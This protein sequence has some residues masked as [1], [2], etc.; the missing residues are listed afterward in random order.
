[1][2]EKSIAMSPLNRGIM[3]LSFIRCVLF[4]PLRFIYMNVYICYHGK[5]VN[6]ASFWKGLLSH[7]WA[8]FF[9]KPRLCKAH[10]YVIFYC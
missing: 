6:Y 3:A 8:W 4:Y 5:I 7:L 10:I 1:M 9:G 2:T